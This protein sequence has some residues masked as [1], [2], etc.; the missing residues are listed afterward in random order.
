MT[1]YIYG[2][3]QR[4]FSIGC[5]PKEG[6]IKQV[7]SLTGLYHDLIVYNRRLTDKELKE[8]ELDEVCILEGE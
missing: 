5:Q 2:M 7:D 6:F 3:R 4:G 1:K 8:Y